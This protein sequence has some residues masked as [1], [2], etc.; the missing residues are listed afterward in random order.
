MTIVI[1]MLGCARH[2]P[3]GLTKGRFSLL[4]LRLLLWRTLKMR[5][6]RI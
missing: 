5:S 6:P 3:I 1:L 2:T 4:G